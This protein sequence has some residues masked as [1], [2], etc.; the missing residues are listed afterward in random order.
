MRNFNQ[1]SLTDLSAA[2]QA[3]ADGIKEILSRVDSLHWNDAG[4]TP[5]IKH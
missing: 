1:R 3:T 2:A 4:M 5:E